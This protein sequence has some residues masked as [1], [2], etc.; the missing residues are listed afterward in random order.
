[1]NFF[2]QKVKCQKYLGGKGWVRIGEG[3]SR[4]VYVKKKKMDYVIKVPII[5]EAQ[6]ENQNESKLSKKESRYAHCRLIKLFGIDCLLMEYLD[7]DITGPGVPTW[8]THVDCRQVGR[9]SDGKW[10][11][12]DFPDD[13]LGGQNFNKRSHDEIVKTAL[14]KKEIK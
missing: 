14:K 2:K 13:P 4:T 9:N 11:A 3:T 7:P 5:K 12:Y 6:Q 10:K 8:S 1:M